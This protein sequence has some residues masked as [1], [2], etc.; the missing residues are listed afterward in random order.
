MLRINYL[1][2]QLTYSHDPFGEEWITALCAIPFC[3]TPVCP[4]ILSCEIFH[5][6]CNSRFGFVLMQGKPS[7]VLM[8]SAHYTLTYRRIFSF[9]NEFLNRNRVIC[10]ITQ[11][12]QSLSNCSRPCEVSDLC[13]NTDLS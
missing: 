3:S 11:V 6:Y 10:I 2:L 7:S 8:C 4:S 1:D 5:C 9:A 13:R 12:R